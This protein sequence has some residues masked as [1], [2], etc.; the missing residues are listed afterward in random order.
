M[1]L[2]ALRQP[3]STVKG[4]EAV[5]DSMVTDADRGA[6]GTATVLKSASEILNS[7]KPLLSSSSGSGLGTAGPADLHRFTPSLKTDVC[8]GG[9]PLLAPGTG[10]ASL[11]EPQSSM[12][13]HLTACLQASKA[14]FE[15]QVGAGL[16]GEP[17]QT[18]DQSRVI[19]RRKRL[20]LA[21]TTQLERE[22]EVN[23]KW[24]QSDV[25]RLSQQLKLQP[26]KL[27]KWHWD[28]KKRAE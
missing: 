8:A 12:E 25:M 21:Q 24:T 10:Q 3:G 6:Q 16:V 14:S 5:V 11:G 22:F 2:N 13:R 27:Y 26:K 20:T 1:I 7:L 15:Q 17:S 18:R 19:H 28:R 9:V 4:T 23:P